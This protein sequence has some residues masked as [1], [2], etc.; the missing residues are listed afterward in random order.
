MENGKAVYKNFHCAD[1]PVTENQYE[2]NRVGRP[3]ASARLPFQAKNSPG[4]GP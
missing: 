2:R 1:A 3:P 4:T